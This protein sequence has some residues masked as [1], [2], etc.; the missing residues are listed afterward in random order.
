[1]SEYLGA[2]RDPEPK[3]PLVNVLIEHHPNIGDIISNRYLKVMFKS[4]KMGLLPN[5]VSSKESITGWWVL[6]HSQ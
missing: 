2:V 4:P 5:P 1:M 6:S 3:L